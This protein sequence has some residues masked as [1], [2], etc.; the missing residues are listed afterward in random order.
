MRKKIETNSEIKV[1]NFDWIPKRYRGRK[2][3]IKNYKICTHFIIY[4]VQ[5]KNRKSLLELMEFDVL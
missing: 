1:A 4:N 2:G 3:V 5:V